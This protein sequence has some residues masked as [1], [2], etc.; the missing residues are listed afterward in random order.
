MSFAGR[1]GSLAPRCLHDLLATR[2]FSQ[3]PAALV[4][5]QNARLLSSNQHS[6]ADASTAAAQDK[7]SISWKLLASAGLLGALLSGQQWLSGRQE[8][9]CEQAQASAGAVQVS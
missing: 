9:H 5:A 4:A 8:S 2:A 7:A 3:S 1:A 6:G